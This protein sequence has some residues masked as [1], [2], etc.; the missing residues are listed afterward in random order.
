MSRFARLA[1][2]YWIGGTLAAF[3]GVA[4]ARLVAPS[5]EGKIRVYVTLAGQLLALA[6]LL[7][8]CI[9]VRQ[10]LRAT[11]EEDSARES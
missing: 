4:L 2:R 9:G 1:N 10:R 11:P 3:G 8:I 5:L 7:V 6:G